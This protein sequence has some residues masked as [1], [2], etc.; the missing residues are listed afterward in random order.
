VPPLG[1]HGELLP[2]CRSRCGRG[3]LFSREP[4]QSFDKRAEL[5]LCKQGFD[6]I[7]IQVIRPGVLKVQADVDIGLDLRQFIAHV[8]LVFVLL[9]LG[10]PA[11]LDLIDVGVDVVESAEFLEQRDGRLFT[12][13]GHAR[14][15]IGLVA[16]QRLVIHNLV[17]ATPSLA[18]TSSSVT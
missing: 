1:E 18:I 10:L 17:R 6:R 13:A 3:R 8:G 5:Q 16:D 15:V 4:L 11:V 12:N 7:E 14:D 9:E 2:R